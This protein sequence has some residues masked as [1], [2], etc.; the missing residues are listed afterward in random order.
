MKL[1]CKG[2]CFL[3][4][5]SYVGFPIVNDYKYGGALL[6]DRLEQLPIQ[7]SVYFSVV[8]LLC[9]PVLQETPVLMV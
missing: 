7:S 2:C 4:E 5:F 6:E 3:C 8:L 9:M 1:C